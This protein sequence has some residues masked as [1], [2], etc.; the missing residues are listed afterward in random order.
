MRAVAETRTLRGDTVAAR[1]NRDRRADN[2]PGNARKSRCHIRT[3]SCPDLRCLASSQVRGRLTGPGRSRDGSCLSTAGRPTQ[4]RSLPCRS[5]R[6]KPVLAAMRTAGSSPCGGVAD[7]A[8]PPPSRQRRPVRSRRIGLRS[9]G[10][11]DPSVRIH[12][13]GSPR[14]SR[15]SLVVP[16]ASGNHGDHGGRVGTYAVQGAR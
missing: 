2:T 8:G 15:V 5:A 13:D 9:E 4:G 6:A 16:C 7:G 14:R 10:L 3:R 11:A 12:R 1:G